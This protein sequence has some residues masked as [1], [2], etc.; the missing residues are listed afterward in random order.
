MTDMAAEGYL[1]KNGFLWPTFFYANTR[2]CRVSIDKW[3]HFIAPLS[4]ILFLA[5]TR[6]YFYWTEEDI[7]FLRF[8]NSFALQR[9]GGRTFWNWKLSS[10]H[11]QRLYEY[12][13]YLQAQERSNLLYLKL[14]YTR[15]EMEVSSRYHFFFFKLKPDPPSLCL[16][17]HVQAKQTANT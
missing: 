9:R 12:I 8:S 16:S 6:A 15:E 3:V 14:A 13:I 10:F 17:C 7:F 1:I 11:D 5:I 2:W 4:S